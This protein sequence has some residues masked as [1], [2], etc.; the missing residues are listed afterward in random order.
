MTPEEHIDVVIDTWQPDCDNGLLYASAGLVGEAGEIASTVAKFLRG[1][2]SG[3]GFR[4]RVLSELGDVAWFLQ[5]CCWQ[6]GVSLGQVLE[7]NAQ[8]VQSRKARGVIRGDGDR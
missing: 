7:D 6:A 4:L 5:A 8:K 3:A 1:D 2:F